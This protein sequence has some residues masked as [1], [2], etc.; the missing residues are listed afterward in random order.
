VR[1]ETCLVQGAKRTDKTKKQKKRISKILF[2]AKQKKQKQKLDWVIADE[3]GKNK[4][5]E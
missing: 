4:Q 5:R 2:K 3:Q 1:A